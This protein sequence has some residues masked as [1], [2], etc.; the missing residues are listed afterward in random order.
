MNQ[1]DFSQHYLTTSPIVHKQLKDIFP[2]KPLSLFGAK[3]LPILG[4]GLKR[5]GKLAK[6]IAKKNGKDCVLLEDGFI[7]SIELGKEGSPCHAYT[8]DSISPHYDGHTLGDLTGFLQSD[9]SI[10][11]G[12]A[13]RAANAIDYIKEHKISKYNHSP[14]VCDYSFESGVLVISQVKGDLSLQFG[15]SQ[16]DMDMSI[17]DAAIEENP[18]SIIYV[19]VHPDVLA[20]K[21]KSDIDVEKLPPGV[22]LIA[23]DYN[24]MS[25][26][27][28]FDKVYVRTSLMGFEALMLGKE[29]VCF[30]MP[31]YAGWGLTDDRSTL[32]SQR[33]RSRTLEEVFAVAYLKQSFYVDPETHARTSL[34]DAMGLI[35]K[36][37]D[38]LN[39]SVRGKLNYTVTKRVA[40]CFG[41]SRWKRAFLKDYFPEFELHYEGS[42][43][44]RWLGL[45][46]HLKMIAQK[47]S[48]EKNAVFL[49]WG[50][51]Y[52]WLD[53]IAIK[54]NMRLVRV[55]DGFIR[56]LG[57]GSSKTIPMS[58]IADDLG[59]YFDPTQAS[60]LEVILNSIDL[61]TEHDKR[62]RAKRVRE[63]L[64]EQ[65]LS[66]YNLYSEEEL[67]IDTDKRVIFVPGQVDNDASLRFG[68]P[69]MS[70]LALIKKVRA[71]NP[72]A[73]IIYKHHPD[74]LEGARK[75][76]VSA[77]DTNRY[78]DLVLQ[79]VSVSTALNICDEVHV[80]TSLVGFEALLHD[81]KVT[82]YGQPFYAGWG[83]TTDKL[84]HPKRTN[85]V[86]L[87]EL[88]YGTLIQ[89][90][91]YM[92]PLSKKQCSIETVM[93]LLS[94]HSK[95]EVAHEA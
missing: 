49:V 90:P 3:D 94:S 22:R 38:A 6:K 33:T 26:L 92:N 27:E 28:H 59:V 71:E 88:V 50:K 61:S 31:F 36:K 84:E 72:D 65:K 45:E 89:Y 67:A 51:S 20:G 47:L 1:F 15:C 35:V 5:T 7:R 53:D 42:N 52:E 12:D 73:F 29:V 24:P 91:V 87:D 39:L 14:M 80:M 77:V 75:G 17:V 79:K 10:S 18:D 58:L 74:V 60:R 76:F 95:G 56:S 16:E 43:I 30:G 86:T 66:K 81:K 54:S 41:F 21:A 78:C 25:L 37:R 68:A 4:W 63:F 82:C 44:E 64:V 34:E 62:E 85:K 13:V 48:E 93:G 9:E 55:E 69:N 70:N 23:D 8:F 40:Y 57:L 19:K 83:L 46:L 2:V 11:V 32:S